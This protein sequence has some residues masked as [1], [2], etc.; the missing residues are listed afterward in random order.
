[1]SNLSEALKEAYARSETATRHLMALELQHS[2]FPGGVIRVVNYHKDLYVDGG[3]YVAHA[4]EATEPAVGSEPAEKATI[5]IDGVSGDMHF[6]LN[7]AVITGTAVTA[8]L[9]PFALNT[10]TDAVIDVIGVFSL[11]VLKASFDMT[12]VNIELG[13]AAPTNIPFPGKRYDPVTYPYLYK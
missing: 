3:L 10:D 8:D 13:H 11:K 9:R 4:M 1:M 5:V 2:E 7:A 6:F 12:K